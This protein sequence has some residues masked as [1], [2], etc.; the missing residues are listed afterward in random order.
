MTEHERKKLVPVL[1]VEDDPDDVEITKRAFTRGRI[2]NP[3]Y[4]VRDGEEALEFMRHTGRYPSPGG[5]PRPGLILLDLNLPRLSGRD[6]LRIVKTDAALRRIPVVVLTTSDEQTDV[7]ECYDAG[8]NS[9]LTKPVVFENFIDAVIT[10]GK[11]WLCLAEIP[12]N[13]ASP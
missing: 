3:L 5:A 6:L 1:L 2:A 12:S 11:Y 8:A 4:V 13:G 7:R 10:I 9:Y